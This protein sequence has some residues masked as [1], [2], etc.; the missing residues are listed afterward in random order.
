MKSLLTYVLIIFVAGCS[1]PIVKTLTINTEFTTLV[2]TRSIGLRPKIAAAPG[3][4]VILLLHGI[5]DHCPGYGL[6]PR[7][8]WFSTEVV[9]ALNLT[10]VGLTTDKITIPDFDSNDTESTLIVQRDRY[11]A[12]A[13]HGTKVVDVV[14]ITWSGLDR[15]LKDTQLGYDIS[16]VR[17]PS[18]PASQLRPGD[19]ILDCVAPIG[20]NFKQPRVAINAAFKNGL[21]DRNLA[22]AVVYAG[23]YG[24]KI[25]REVGDAL[26]RVLKDDWRSESTTEQCKWT[27]VSKS[28]TTQLMFVT[29][30]LGS[31]IAYDTI[32]DLYGSHM[33]PGVDVFP[34][35]TVTDAH[36]AIQQLLANTTAIYMMANQLPLLG[37][38]DAKP[39]QKSADGDVRL[40]LPPQISAA[41]A[42]AVAK[43]TELSNKILGVQGAL[44]PTPAGVS[45]KFTRGSIEDK[46]AQLREIR[47]AAWHDERIELQKAMTA[48]PDALL[49][50]KIARGDALSDGPNPIAGPLDI[51]AF[52]DPNDLL[53]YSLPDWYAGPTGGAEIRIHN[54]F[55]HNA[56]RW[57]WLFENPSAAHSNYMVNKDVWRSIACGFDPQ[58]GPSCDPEH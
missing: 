12:P 35:Q 9:S 39:S 21:L 15:W 20:G 40:S 50:F 52:S 14:E 2:E 57:L 5:G 43:Q 34:Q 51:V 42:L 46:A 33:R 26:C 30:S 25:E 17:K 48:Q 1:G 13:A 58:K 56:T 44:D 3:A 41:R 16:D 29:H 45:D 10:K 24:P 4:S 22:D 55:V 37:L 36:P 53:S 19:E 32:L 27:S 8:G 31:R 11:T 7:L 38:A 18:K 54:V 23:S 28:F 47:T 49:A 6:D